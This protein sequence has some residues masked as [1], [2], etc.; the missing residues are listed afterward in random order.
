MDVSKI[1]LTD[2]EQCLF[3][4]FRKSDDVELTID[5]YKVLLHKGLIKNS[6]GGNSGWFDDLPE[7]G[8]CSLSDTGK[9]LRAYQAQQNK[10]E[11]QSSRRYWI[12]TA[13]A[14]I[15]LIKAFMPEISA[16]LAW[17]LKLLG[18]Q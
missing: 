1:V 16:G 8:I 11:R 17:L 10:V 7:K 4:R 14:A 5:E 18:Q 15:A 3:D 6:I 12:T 2:V 13:I 9:D